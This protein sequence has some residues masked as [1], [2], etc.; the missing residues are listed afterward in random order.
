VAQTKIC[1]SVSTLTFYDEQSVWQFTFGRRPSATGI[2]VPS[3]ERYSKTPHYP[4][5]S[6]RQL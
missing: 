3:E 1:R 2:R 5:R 6:C 4:P